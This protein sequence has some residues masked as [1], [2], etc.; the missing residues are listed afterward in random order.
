M[1]RTELTAE[2]QEKN[3][4]A[5]QELLVWSSNNVEKVD[6]VKE[7]R[8]QKRYH[9]EVCGHPESGKFLIH[10]LV[11]LCQDISR[12]GPQRLML[13]LRPKGK[14]SVFR[15]EDLDAQETAQAGES[16][17]SQKKHQNS[18]FLLTFCHYRKLVALLN[19]MCFHE[20]RLEHRK[21]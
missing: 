2:G 10:T 18:S 9:V 1:K 11:L 7:T 6:H 17:Q 3:S 21:M 5:V 15:P 14:S 16:G 13:L 12:N 19:K 4:N 20:A 8:W